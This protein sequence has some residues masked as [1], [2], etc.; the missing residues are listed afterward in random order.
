MVILAVLSTGNS[1]GSSNGG[2]IT[3]LE[4]VAV[5]TLLV[6][7]KVMFVKMIKSHVWGGK[8]PGLRRRGGRIFFHR[9][10]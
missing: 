5:F 6:V 8:F 7:Y 10:N 4:L 1:I 3:A 2:S 9:F